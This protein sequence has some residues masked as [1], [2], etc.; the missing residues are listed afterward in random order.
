MHF[1]R[2]G[3]GGAFSSIPCESSPSSGEEDSGGQ[4]ISIVDSSYWPN[5]PW[6]PQLVQMLVG[7]PL[8][9]PTSRSLLYLP[10]DPQA[11]HPL[12]ATLHLTVWPVSGDD[13]KQQDFRRRLSRFSCPH[14]V[15]PPGR[16]T[17][18]PGGHGQL[19]VQSVDVVPFQHL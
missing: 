3:A 12:W 15:S 18:A 6:F 13:S 17:R 5:K 19:G 9:L 7:H 4:S 10:F 14:R 11:Y 1:S 2:T 16:D 8:R